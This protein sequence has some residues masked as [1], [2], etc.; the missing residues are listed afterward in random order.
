MGEYSK[1]GSYAGYDKDHLDRAD[2]DY[3]ATPPE[4]V[5]N[6]LEKEG[7][8]WFT[9]EGINTSCTIWEPCCGGGHMAKGII[10]YLNK[11]HISTTHFFMSDL[12]D[13]GAQDYIESLYENSQ[14]QYDYGIDL[15]DPEEDFPITDF[16]IMNPPFKD[17]DKFVNAVFSCFS[18]KLIM[19][20]RLKFIESKKR[21]EEIFS[22]NPPTRIYQYIDRIACY[23]DG[24]FSIKPNSIEAYAWF[25]WDKDDPSKDT[26]LKWIWSKKHK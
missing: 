5:E 25:V 26:T 18:H 24:D 22:K 6:I 23:K 17:I 10:D 4:E 19:L 2:L 20:A 11:N 16:I 3:Y 9:V 15:L 21:Y 8:R 1:K 13:R 12:V 7:L 14:I